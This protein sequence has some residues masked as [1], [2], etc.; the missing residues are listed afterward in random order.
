M[1][2]ELHAK[3][4]ILEPLYHCETIKD[5]EKEFEGLCITKKA[6][7]GLQVLERDLPLQ[8]SFV[9]IGKYKV[10][11]PNEFICDAKPKGNKNAWN[12]IIHD[13]AKTENFPDK[14]DKQI[15]TITTLKNVTHSSTNAMR[16]YD[17]E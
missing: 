15:K 12:V 4:Q 17:G 1:F 2:D 13:A 3:N 7:W 6:G 14:S 10:D 16:I 9:I 8:K 11:Y 5:T